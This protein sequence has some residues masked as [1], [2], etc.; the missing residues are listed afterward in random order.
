MWSPAETILGTVNEEVTFSYP[1]T[2]EDVDLLTSLT[3]AYPVTIVAVESIPTVSIVENTISG[4]YTDSFTNSIQYLNKNESIVT[5]DKFNKITDLYEMISYNADTTRT[6]TFEY[7]ATAKDPL[8][9]TIVATQVYTIVVQND[10]T[11][12]K[13]NLQS[14]VGATYASNS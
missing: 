1:I 10:W 2:Y 12:G 7:T 5:T 13:N 8:T 11:T 6:K 4:Y 14:Y 3:V 9:D